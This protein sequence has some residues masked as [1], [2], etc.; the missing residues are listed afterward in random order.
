M[1]GLVEQH[2]VR[3]L[4]RSATLDKDAPP[5]RLRDP[6]DKRDRCSQDQRA[7]G[8]RNQHRKAADQIARDE[9]GEQRDAQ[10]DGQEDQRIAVSEA[11]E[12]G[13]RGLCRGDQPHDTG[14]GAFAGGCRCRHLKRLAGVQGAGE[15][16]AAAGF[17]HRDRLPGQCRFIDGRRLRD[18]HAIDGNDLARPYHELVAD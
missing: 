10:G 11:N 8:R 3:T 2:G 15:H 12:R 16:G 18:D 9:P 6:C 1:P 13:L 14:I 5:R 17:G 7:R 4:Q